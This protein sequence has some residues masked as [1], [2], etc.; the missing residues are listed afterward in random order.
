MKYMNAAEGV[1]DVLKRNPGGVD[2]FQLAQETGFSEGSVRNVVTYLV[3]A[4]LAEKVDS[5]NVSPR[6]RRVAKYRLLGGV[7]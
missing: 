4:G 1:M 3:G 7:R 5:D 2:V 6:G